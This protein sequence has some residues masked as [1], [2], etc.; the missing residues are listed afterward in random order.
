MCAYVCAVRRVKIAAAAAIAIVV[1]AEDGVEIGS[2]G[3]GVG[4]ASLKAGER[5][6]Q[7][8]VENRVRCSNGA[9]GE[10]R[11]RSPAG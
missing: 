10:E 3:A 6:E 9:D 7:C 2:G 4:G 11:G 5:Q 8:L 1:A